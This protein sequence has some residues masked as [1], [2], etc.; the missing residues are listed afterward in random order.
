MNILSGVFA[1]SA[2]I[3]V[4]A[5]FGVDTSWTGAESTDWATPGN[6]DNGV[7][8]NTASVGFPSTGATVNLGTEIRTIDHISDYVKNTSPLRFSA[9]EGGGLAMTMTGEFCIG[10]EGNGT[11]IY[12]SGTYTLD[13]HY[14]IGWWHNNGTPY[15]GVVQV[16]S[17]NVTSKKNTMVSVS[18]G[19]G[20]LDVQG[21]SYKVEADLYVGQ[22]NGSQGVLKQSGGEIA[23][24]RVRS[25]NS[26]KVGP[27]S[28]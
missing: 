7:P 11:L 21:G 13:G 27:Y 9:G 20:I 12:D 1:L 25:S 24:K 6:W 5:V 23:Q 3:A 22:D 10:R 18:K 15:T 28:S 8:G 26:D 2:S 4:T 14:R 17:A 16:V 19:Y